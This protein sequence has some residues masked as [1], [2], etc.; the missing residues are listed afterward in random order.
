MNIVETRR[1]VFPILGEATVSLPSKQDDSH[2]TPKD[3]YIHGDLTVRTKAPWRSVVQQSHETKIYMPTM[4]QASP[5]FV[6]VACDEYGFNARTINS[7]TF[8]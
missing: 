5:L 8:F 6:S 7:I 3:S 1:K 2:T 4:K